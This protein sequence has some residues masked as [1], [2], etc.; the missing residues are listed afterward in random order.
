MCI[1]SII[2]ITAAFSTNVTAQQAVNATSVSLPKIFTPISVVKNVD[3]N[4]GVF[5]FND[6]AGNT[7][8]TPAAATK[9]TTSKGLKIRNLKTHSAIEKYNNQRFNLPKYNRSIRNNKSY[10]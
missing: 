5:S 10:R 7:K 9:T 8:L 1:F 3:L 2:T 4:F 6:T